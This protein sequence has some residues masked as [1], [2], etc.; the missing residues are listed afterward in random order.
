MFLCSFVSFLAYKE[1]KPL[2]FIVPPKGIRENLLM[3]FD[4]FKPSANRC[5]G[6]FIKNGFAIMG[7][8]FYY[9]TL[10]FLGVL[11]N[12]VGPLSEA[13]TAMNLRK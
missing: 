6:L 7:F 1:A 10:R 13:G 4:K 11:T 3:L 2:Y 5:D 8:I 12:V 9:L